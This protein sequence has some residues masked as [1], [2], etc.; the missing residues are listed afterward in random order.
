MLCL[1]CCEQSDKEFCSY[2]CYLKA[3]DDI[4]LMIFN[5]DHKKEPT[6]E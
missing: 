6:H 5:R 2:G 4:K 3:S 1:I